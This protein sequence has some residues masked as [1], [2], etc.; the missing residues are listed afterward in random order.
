MYTGTHFVITCCVYNNN[1]YYQFIIIIS[2]IIVITHLI[3]LHCSD[4][5][6]FWVLVDI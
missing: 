4:I 6:L 2:I 5:S 1:N 3:K